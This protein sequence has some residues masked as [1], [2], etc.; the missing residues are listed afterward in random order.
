M[1]WKGFGKDLEG[2]CRGLIVRYCRSIILEKMRKTTKTLNQ[3]SRSPSRDLKQG[4]SEYK[5][6]VLS[7]RPQRSVL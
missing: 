2:S 1:I 7:T 3:D 5:A 4:L 6:G